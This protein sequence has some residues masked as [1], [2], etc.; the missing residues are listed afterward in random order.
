MDYKPDLLRDKSV[1]STTHDAISTVRNTFPYF[2]AVLTEQRYTS[3]RKHLGFLKVGGKKGVWKYFCLLTNKK[4]FQSIK[5]K[6]EL[7]H[8]SVATH[9]YGLRFNKIYINNQFMMEK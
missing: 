6:T 5:N 1:D 2:P 4:Y 9:I 8:L 7:C 3:Q